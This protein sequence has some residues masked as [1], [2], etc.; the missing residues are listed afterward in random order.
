VLLDTRDLSGGVRDYGYYATMAAFG[1]PF[2]VEVDRDQDPRK[3]ARASSFE[4]PERLRV[5]ASEAR[6]R[7]LIAWGDRHRLAA[8]AAGATLVT[9]ETRGAEA[10]RWALLRWP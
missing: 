2:A 4:E 6:A 5:R 1:Y 10:V 9:E 3:P 7:W 8:L